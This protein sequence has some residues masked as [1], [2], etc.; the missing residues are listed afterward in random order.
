MP[1]PMTIHL[2]PLVADDYADVARIF[3]R[4]VHDGT[5]GLY[6]PDQ[7]RAWAG[8]RLEPDGWKARV[9]GLTG[10]M[11]VAE[12]GPAGFLTIDATG[13][14]DL[15]FVLP[16]HARKGIGTLL[17]RAAETWAADHGATR[18]RTEASL[19][20]RPFFEKNGWQVVEREEILRRG[21]T[22]SR[23]RMD[24]LLC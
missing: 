14:V 6:T 15:A 22:L 18:L 2:R 1:A 3:F 10:V 16:T 4:A 21:V 13:H 11:A 9:A 12:D 20:A 5:V 19:A 17:L 24:K 8:E 23:F 7:R